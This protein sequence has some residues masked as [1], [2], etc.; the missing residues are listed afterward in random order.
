MAD[1]KNQ[2]TPAPVDADAAVAR[3]QVEAASALEQARLEAAEKARREAEEL[4]ARTQF[5]P[6]PDSSIKVDGTVEVTYLGPDGLFVF[7]VNSKGET[8]SARP[9]ETVKVSAEMRDY[10]L[11]L[12]HDLFET[13]KNS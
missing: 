11:T 10:V 6:K 2:V 12:P 7:G 9:G 8:V 5:P 1:E 4:Q 3:R 13:A